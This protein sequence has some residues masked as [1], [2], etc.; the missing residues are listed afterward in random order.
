MKNSTLCLMLSFL[1]LGCTHM[2]QKILSRSGEVRFKGV[3]LDPFR[4]NMPNAR[5]ESASAWKHI[6]K[7]KAVLEVT[8]TNTGQIYSMDY[9]PNEFGDGFTLSLPYGSYRYFSEVEGGKFRRYLPFRIEG[10]FILNA[11][12]LDITLNATTDYGLITVRN[13]YLSSLEIRHGADPYGMG[14]LEDGTHYFVYIRNGLNPTLE[15]KDIFENQLIT[16]EIDVQAYNHYSFFLKLA[17]VNGNANFVELALGGFEYFSIGITLGEAETGTF[18]DPRD[19]QVYKTVQ[20]GIHTWMAEN[21]NY[22][23]EYSWCYGEDPANCEKYGRLYSWNT[24]LTVCPDGWHLP[25]RAEWEILAHY[26]GGWEI[27]GGKM[28]STTGWDPPN[29][30]ATNESGFSALPGGLGESVSPDN[31]YYRREASGKWWGADRLW[32]DDWGWQ[33]FFTDLE[34]SSQELT[35]GWSEVYG[36]RSCRCIRD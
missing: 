36:L 33:Y 32:Y 25:S 7:D 18:T 1:L 16:R 30:G 2:D 26:L 10:E 12:S 20:I 23:P 4:G 13:Q 6:F 17:Q 3:S 11:E 31:Y 22:E 21:L 28:K 14:L 24:A 8:D 29:T 34:H 5:T 35:W 27:A 19:G 15:I 9:N